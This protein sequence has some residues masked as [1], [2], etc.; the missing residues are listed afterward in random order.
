MSDFQTV[1]QAVSL[2][3]YAEAKLDRVRGGYVCP[4]CGSGKGPSKSPAFSV[5]K[6]D[7]TWKCFS[8]GR[9]GD[10]FDL[11]A[12]VEGLDSNDKRA[13]LEAVASWA[14]IP[15]IDL[16]EIPSAKSPTQTKPEKLEPDYSI[17]RD[18]ERDYLTQCRE[19]VN[20]P[21]ALDYLQGRGFTLD[22][23]AA[24]GFGYDPAPEHGWQDVSGAWHNTG[25]VVIPWLG[26][27]YYHVDRAIDDRAKDRKYI[28][29][30]SDQLG[31][32]P[33]YNP[34]AMAQPAFFIVEGILDALAIKACGYEAIALAG[35]NNGDTLNAISKASP[36]TERPGIAIVMM[37]NDKAGKTA[38]RGILTT[39]KES[40]VI[41]TSAEW[42][43]YK[44]AGEW[45]AA[46]REGLG[47]FLEATY[48]QALE[49]YQEEKENRLDT[50]LKSFRIR[51]PADVATD[52]FLGNYYETPLPTGLK[53]LDRVLCGGLKTGLH[54]LGAVS[55]LGKTTLALQ[56]ADNIAASGRLVLFVTIEQSAGELTAKSLNRYLYRITDKVFP[57]WQILGDNAQ[58]SIDQHVAF[59]NACDLYG[60][61]VAPNLRIMEGTKQPTVEDI[62][63]AAEYMAEYKGQAP[64]IF[65]DYLQLLAPHSDRDSD[66][67]AVDRNVMALRQLARDL[68]VPV[69]V[70]SS[71]NR[72]SYSEGVN[73]ES[74]KESGAVE[75]GSD[76]LLGLQ[77]KGIEAT[78]EN[79][80]DKAVKR[81]SHKFM[82]SHKSNTTREC[83]LVIL[84]NRNGITPK[85]NL[86]L[87]FEAGA[88]L[89]LEG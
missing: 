54:T 48:N 9:G 69:F 28:K 32:Q 20:S 21:E 72:S 14:N 56:V 42:G 45:F 38:Q 16:N 19:R 73:L 51:N 12:V 7:T 63:V 4:A 24:F 30:K 79:A 55:S 61:E 84:K 59:G 67:Q 77:A 57:T 1:K 66:K 13:H 8:C 27:D 17:G 49:T 86:V 41:A 68:R 58:W 89:F 15:L 35:T 2:K 78:A 25:R 29:P 85:E 33:I 82:R 80:G 37:D 5:K 11:A 43:D 65:V 31:P 40:N 6:Q 23:I 3:E 36:Q 50:I 87:T 34:G 18:R 64:V 60:R 44:D 26:C 81:A 75:Y 74:F 70:I 10:V 47:S 46:D 39:L 71:L 22:E 52:I 88:S 53:Q 76:V 62:R 83:E